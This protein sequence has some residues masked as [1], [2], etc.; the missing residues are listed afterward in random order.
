MKVVLVGD[1]RVGKTS[2]LNRLTT[3]IFKENTTATVG[4]AFQT[5]VLT[6]AAGCVTMQ[7]WD[8]A[9]QEKYRSLAPMYYRSASVALLCFDITN[10]DSFRALESWAAELATKA[11]SDLRTILVG[12]KLDLAD[13]RVIALHDAGDFAERHNVAEYIECSAKTG[14]GIIELFTRAAQFLAPAVTSIPRDHD[15]PNYPQRK[16]SDDNK[17]C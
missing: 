7:I 2:I 6:T 1:S 3:G 8:T 17:C 10:R 13:G 14:D 16:D 9:G 15:K 4:A 12:N 11:A 5:H